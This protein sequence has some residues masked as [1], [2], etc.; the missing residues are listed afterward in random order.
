MEVGYDLK[1]IIIL[2]FVNRY[3]I[4]LFNYCMNY[5]DDCF[6]IW[7]FFFLSLRVKVVY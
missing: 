7:K 6:F 3:C 5:F 4:F 1:L 2:L